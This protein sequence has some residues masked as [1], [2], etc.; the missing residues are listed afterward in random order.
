VSEVNREPVPAIGE[1]ANAA[2]VQRL[3]EAQSKVEHRQRVAKELASTEGTFQKDMRLLSRLGSADLSQILTSSH[4]REIFKKMGKAAGQLA[5]LSEEYLLKLRKI[6][7]EALAKNSDPAKAINDLTAAYLNDPKVASLFKQLTKSRFDLGSLQLNPEEAAAISNILSGD[8]DSLSILAVQR[9]PRYSLLLKELNQAKGPL[10]CGSTRAS[11][12]DL[13]GY[14]G[15]AC[16]AQKMNQGTNSS[17]SDEDVL[18]GMLAN[19]GSWFSRIL[20]GSKSSG[21]VSDRA[22]KG[23][24]SSAGSSEDQSQGSGSSISTGGK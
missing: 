24:G 22:D 16:A 10:D 6:N 3:A 11:G 23:G 2:R 4:E 13:D 19:I 14:Q 1:A 8:L 12:S 5:E 21:K 15:A 17:A 18:K 9:G 7:E 20:P